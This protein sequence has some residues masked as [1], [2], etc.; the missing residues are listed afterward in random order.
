MIQYSIKFEQD[1]ECGGG[2]IKLL[3]GY[4]NQKKFGGDTPYRF[5]N[6]LPCTPTSV[7]FILKFS[8]KKKEYI[9]KLF[10]LCQFAYMKFTYLIRFGKHACCVILLIVMALTS[11]YVFCS[12]MFG[13]DLCGSQTKKLHLILSYQ[14]QN[15]PIKKDLQCETDKLTHFYTFI[16]RP[17]ATYSVLVDN[18]ERDSGS[19]YMDWDI[20][21]PQ[22]IKDVNA[23]KVLFKI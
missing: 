18:R 11:Q 16:L 22:K 2:Y 13:P 10:C 8:P 7:E 14:G 23:R 12:F 19:M 21:P 5:V 15:Y 4:V 9:L 1:I 20:L 17:D 3:S 6:N